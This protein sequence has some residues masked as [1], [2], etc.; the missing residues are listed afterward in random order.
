MENSEFTP[1]VHTQRRDI[2]FPYFIARQAF[3]PDVADAA[4]AWLDGCVSWRR[5]RTDFFDQFECS[6]LTMRLPPPLHDGL[7]S[8]TMLRTLRQRME[9]IF[10]VSLAD[11]FTVTGHRL[12][13]GQGIGVHTDRPLPG[14][15]TYRMV[16]HLG[17]GTSDANGGHLMFLHGKEPKDFACAFRGVHNTAVGFEL[18]EQSFHAVAELT[19][20]V[21]YTLVYSFWRADSVGEIRAP[22]MRIDEVTRAQ[23][24]QAEL[25]YAP[26]AASGRALDVLL[27]L[28]VAAGAACTPQPESAILP[29]LV[30][31]YEILRGWQCSDAVCLAGLFHGVYGT[32]ASPEPLLPLRQRQRVREVIGEQAEELVYACCAASDESL[33]QALLHGDP[34]LVE[35]RFRQ[36]PLRLDAESLTALATLQLAHRRAMHSRHRPTDQAWAA[37]RLLFALA[38]PHLDVRVR[39]ALRNVYG[40]EPCAKPGA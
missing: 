22:G 27:E 14:Y 32:T 4:Y 7:V 17:S 30:Q 9:Q 20:G 12:V 24:G 31:T 23:S 3:A 35:D 36:A 18:S 34:G 13:P 25:L 21:R 1:L 5:H 19:S 38:A 10:S 33:L 8:P 15:E 39:Q 6:L 2:P 28:L 16:V 37:E 26:H 40:D 29:D 11:V